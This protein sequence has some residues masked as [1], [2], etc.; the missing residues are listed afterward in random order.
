MADP[1][2]PMDATATARAPRRRCARCGRVAELDAFPED[3]AMA[4]GRGRVC[5][6]CPPSASRLPMIRRTGGGS[7]GG[8]VESPSLSHPALSSTTDKDPAA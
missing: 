8:F 6:A 2:S 1:A 7:G 5:L 3:L 4:L